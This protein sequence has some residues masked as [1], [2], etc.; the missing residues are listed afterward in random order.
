MPTRTERN[1]FL[2]YEATEGGAGVLI[3][4][5][6]EPDC[7]TAVARRALQ[8]MHFDISD[9]GPLPKDST[10]FVD[11]P[12]TACVAACYR[13]LMSY[14]NQPDHELIDRRDEGVRWVLLRLASGRTQGALTS[15]PLAPN[16]AASEAA[17]DWTGEASRRALPPSDAEPLVVGSISVPLVWRRHYVAVLVAEAEA[18]IA[19]QLD[20]LGFEVI[21][22]GERS[23][24]NSTFDRL[25]AVLGRQA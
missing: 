20:D 15:P 12:G 9:D 22:F 13:C 2:C 7:L 8:V 1:G 3:R 17:L 6:A 25:A 5:V 23:T 10:V 14:Y 24:W 4:L 16:P 11:Q 19:A 18:N 21:R